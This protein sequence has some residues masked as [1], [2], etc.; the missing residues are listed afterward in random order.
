MKGRVYGSIIVDLDI[1]LLDDKKQESFGSW[2]DRHL[3]VELAS[4]DRS[5]DYSA[6]IA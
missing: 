4:R 5:T 2:L 6:A 3:S 1:D